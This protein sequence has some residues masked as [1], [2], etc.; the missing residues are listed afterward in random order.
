MS[1]SPKHHEQVA[2]TGFLQQL[3]AHRQ[4]RIH[5][6]D[7]DREPAVAL[8]FL[9]HV[10]VEREAEDNEDVEA[11][12]MDGLFGGFL[13]LLRADRAVLGADGDS[14]AMRLAV[15]VGVLAGGLNPLAG[16][17]LEAREHEALEAGARDDPTSRAKLQHSWNRCFPVS[18]RTRVKDDSIPFELA[19]G[20]GAIALGGI[21]SEDARTDRQR[22]SS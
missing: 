22:L 20:V 5:P 13:H 12:A 21:G 9:G 7:E 3:V 17:R 8:R 4:I 2:G 6:R 1:G 15:L 10:R 11:D 18:I 16:V 19:S 14:D